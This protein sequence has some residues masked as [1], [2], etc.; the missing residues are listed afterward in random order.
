LTGT[1][2]EFASKSSLSTVHISWWRER[3]RDFAVCMIDPN[4]GEHPEYPCTLFLLS[5]RHVDLPHLLRE[6]ERDGVHVCVELIAARP[7]PGASC[8]LL[9]SLQTKA[10]CT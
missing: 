6:R 3:E 7:M 1:P 2:P 5:A 4:N 10:V 8:V 9:Y